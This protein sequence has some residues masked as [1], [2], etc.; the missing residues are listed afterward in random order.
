MYLCLECQNVFDEP[1]NYTETHGLDSPPYE[2][3]SGCPM[4]GGTY[5]D[6]QTCGQ[7]GEWITGEYIELN[8]YTVIC[9]GCYKIKHVEDMG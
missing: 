1:R 9:D 7:C 5:V 4:C 3:W 2:I 8:D 6:A